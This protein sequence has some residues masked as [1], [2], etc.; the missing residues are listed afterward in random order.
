MVLKKE[1][2]AFGT[3]NMKIQHTILLLCAIAMVA[4]SCRTSQQ[5]M[6]VAKDAFGEFDGALVLIDCSSGQAKTYNHDAANTRLPPCSAFKIVNALIGM[7]EGI[8]TSAQQSFYQWDGVERT[9]PTWNRDL[10]FREA[11]Q[12]SCVPAFQNL[13]RQIGTKRMQNWIDK[14]DYGN[15]DTSAGIDVFWLPAPGRKT[16][17]ISPAEQ[18]ELMRRVITADVPFSAASL[19]TLKELMFIKKTERGRL[20]GKT[21][22]GADDEGTFALG[23]F[24]GYTESRGKTYAFACSAQGKN[25]MSKQARN[26]VESVLQKEGLL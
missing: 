12:A 8:V 18:A 9:I 25:V 24:V 17:M 1:R 6:S 19:A 3:N 22:S 4:T 16:V 13:A 15:C 11:F 10:S 20:Y 7:E 2:Q 5:S 21:G 14:I 23:W 26:I